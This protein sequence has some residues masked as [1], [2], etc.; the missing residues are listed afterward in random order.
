VILRLSAFAAGCLA[1]AILVGTARS[2]DK[3]ADGRVRIV[4]VATQTT[5]GRDSGTFQISGHVTDHGRETGML[6]QGPGAFIIRMT[7]RGRKGTFVVRTRE[8]E[9]GPG[10]TGTWSFLSGTNAYRGM[11]G[12]GSLSATFTGTGVRKLLLGS[13]R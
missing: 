13:I 6:T 4:V 2:A 5:P 1:T 3:A 10:A 8:I 9:G 7:L 11:H 12:G